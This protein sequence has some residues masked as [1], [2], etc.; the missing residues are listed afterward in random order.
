MAL[1]L[2]AAGAVDGADIMVVIAQR[3]ILGS[4]GA[5]RQ[6]RDFHSGVKATPLLRP[7]VVGP[8]AA[9]GTKVFSI[10]FFSLNEDRRTNKKM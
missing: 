4:S 5:V 2:S 1:A 6:A 9:D 10:T 8:V 3:H 7:P